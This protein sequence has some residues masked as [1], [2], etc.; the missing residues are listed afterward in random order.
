[1]LV[2]GKRVGDS[3]RFADVAGDLHSW[4]QNYLGADYHKVSVGEFDMYVQS[5]STASKNT[6]VNF[7]MLLDG[8]E[9]GVMSDAVFVKHGARMMNDYKE[10]DKVLSWE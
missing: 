1:M 5:D 3:G 7:R 4:L 10:I 8:E 2:Y 6:K 9:V